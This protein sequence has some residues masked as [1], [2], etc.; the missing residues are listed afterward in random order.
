MESARFAIDSDQIF[1]LEHLPTLDGLLKAGL[2][3]FVDKDFKKYHDMT[4]TQYAIAKRKPNT[5]RFLLQ[6]SKDLKISDHDILLPKTS[7][8]RSGLL[9]L[10]VEFGSKDFYDN[11]DNSCLNIVI[12]VFQTTIEEE[13]KYTETPLALA[14]EKKK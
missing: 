9:K 3:V 8:T 13:S 12:E 11:V 7:N 5:L 10:A 6:K 4:L 14:I 2:T 1:Y